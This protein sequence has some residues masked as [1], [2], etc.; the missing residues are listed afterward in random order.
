MKPKLQCTSN[1]GISETRENLVDIKTKHIHQ[2]WSRNTARTKIR[3]P[4]VVSIE[5]YKTPG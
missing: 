4:L 1:H 5:E 3:L 2:Y